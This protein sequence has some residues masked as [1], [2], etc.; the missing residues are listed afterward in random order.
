MKLL[1]VG[2]SGAVGAKVLDQCLAHPDVTTVIAFV[3]RELPATVLSHSKLQRVI[4]ED[5]AKWEDDELRPHAD[6]AAMVW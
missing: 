2:A 3:R 6:A 1:F 4:K 5:F